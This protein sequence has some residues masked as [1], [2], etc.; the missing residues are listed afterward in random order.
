MSR[1]S[2]YIGIF[3]E[4]AAEHLENL[5]LGLLELELSPEDSK[6]IHS[7]LRAAHTLK[8]SAKM[9]GLEHIGE[10][11]HIME[12]IFKE[13]EESRI[14]ISPETVDA[15]LAGTDIIKE[16]VDNVGAGSEGEIDLEEVMGKL[17]AVMKGEPAPAPQEETSAEEEREEKAKAE[18]E[19]ETQEETPPEPEVEKEAPPEPAE[20]AAKPEKETPLPAE[21][22]KNGTQTEP[23]QKRIQT[24]QERETIRVDTK[25]LDDLLNVAG[26]LLINK[27]KMES[28]THRLA[29]ILE[30][31]DRTGSE[32]SGNGGDPQQAVNRLA[33]IIRET[34]DELAELQQHLSDSVVELDLFSQE[35]RNYAMNLRVLP[36][37]VLFDEFYRTVRDFSRQMK[38]EIRLEITGGET[39]LDK[40]LI[41]ELRPALVHIIRN[42]CD[43]GIEMPETRTKAGKSREGVI[44]IHAYHKGH[45]VIVEITDDGAGIDVDKVRQVAVDKGIISRDVADEMSDQEAMYLILRPG[46]TTSAIITDI[47]GRGVGMDVVKTNIERIKG[48]ITIDSK[49]GEST[50]MTLTAPLTLSIMNALLVQ[51]REDIYSIPLTYVQETVRLPVES[52]FT[53]AGKDVFN[54]RGEI[55]PL[56][57][58]ETMLAYDAISQIEQIPEKVPV[59]VLKF[60]NQKLG[61]IVDHYLR[62]QEIVVKSIGNFLGEVPFAGGVTVLRYGEPSI[63]LNIFDVFATA[64]KWAEMGILEQI[65]RAIEDKP[66]LK[67]LVVDDSITTRMMEKSILEAAGYNVDLAVSGEE[68]REL[69]AKNEYNLVVTDVEM[70]GING[71]ELTELIKTNESTKDMPVVVVTSLASDEDKRRGIEVGAQAYIVK[72]TFDQTTLLDT[73]RSLIN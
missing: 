41:E 57:K 28:H 20:K 16:I 24:H 65:E 37:N 50:K 38:K 36:A 3:R 60:R 25:K 26:E 13:I 7:L 9:L 29:Q 12:D 18:V 52:I 59:V 35:I 8:G 51:V 63:I 55:V 10:V 48:D 11:A 54:I 40:Q 66:E 62:D 31:Y 4:E 2:K 6:L 15:L 68:A 58:L 72:G 14:D 5:S 43:H 17:T 42:C 23:A 70:P 71:F 53:E 30:K 46:F 69:L 73:I 22:E 19:A 27:T 39:E 1:Q 32:E 56:V 67:I 47:S 45:N 21:P 61:M 44:R 34:F 49:P 64:E 33:S